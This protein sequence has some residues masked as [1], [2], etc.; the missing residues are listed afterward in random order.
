MIALA[1]LGAAA[2]FAWLAVFQVALA[3]RAP[4]GRMAWGGRHPV[5][6]AHLRWASLAA[7]LLCALGVAAALQAAG[8]MAVLPDAALRPLLLGLALLFALSTLGNAM[9]ASRPERLHGTPVAAGLALC[10]LI[11]GLTV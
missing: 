7:A 9:S 11:L 2:L 6:P 1:G 8:R 3:A 4:L 10:C 5:L